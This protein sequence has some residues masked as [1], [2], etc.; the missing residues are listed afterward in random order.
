VAGLDAA[1]VGSCDPEAVGI[2]SRDRLLAAEAVAPEER[3]G[4]AL[5]GHDVIGVAERLGGAVQRVRE[6]PEREVG[7]PQRPSRPEI[8]RAVGTRRAAGI[9]AEEPRAHLVV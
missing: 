3:E 1:K 5:R 4:D 7:W 8:E 9:H 6:D 2:G